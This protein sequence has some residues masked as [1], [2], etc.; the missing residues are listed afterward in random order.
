[1]TYFSHDHSKHVHTLQKHKFTIRSVVDGVGSYIDT[2]LVR[3]FKERAVTLAIA[4]GVRNPFT[5]SLIVNQNQH[6]Y[7]FIQSTQK[8]PLSRL[9]EEPITCKCPQCKLVRYGN[10]PAH[11]NVALRV[12]ISIRVVPAAVLADPEQIRCQ[13]LLRKRPIDVAAR[14]N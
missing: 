7:R 11:R 14:R 13:T 10:A 2:P 3:C 6:E 8:G 1:M 5:P 12:V 4:Y 9:I